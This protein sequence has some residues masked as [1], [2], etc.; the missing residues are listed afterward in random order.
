MA[1]GGAG[2]EVNLLRQAHER[3][4][5]LADDLSRHRLDLE[6]P[7]PSVPAPAL[8]EGEAAVRKAADAAAALRERL[9]EI[10][11]RQAPTSPSTPTDQGRT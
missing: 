3:A 2:D 4:G 5:R 6:K 7:W 1:T 8:A 9:A 10:L 11:R